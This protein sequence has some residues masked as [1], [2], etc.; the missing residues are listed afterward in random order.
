[1][2]ITKRI[3]NQYLRS[4]LREYTNT[5]GDT[6]NDEK[7]ALSAWVTS[8]NSVLENPYLLY[9]E[10]GVMMDFI[11]GCRIGFDMCKNPS[12]YSWGDSAANGGA[13]PKPPEFIALSSNPD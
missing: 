12:E 13:A 10:N 6:T 2:V 7:K 11:T 1:M 4:E 5:I 8:G 3:H 9:D